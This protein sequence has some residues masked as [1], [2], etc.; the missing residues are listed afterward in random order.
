MKLTS[1]NGVI[2]PSKPTKVWSPYQQDLFDKATSDL[3][4]H[5]VVEA[6][7]GGAKTTSG[8]HIFSLLPTNISRLAVAFNKHIQAEF[9]SKLPPGSEA[10][11]YHAL[12]FAAIRSSVGNVKV[13]EWKLDNILKNRVGPSGKFMLPSIK[14]IIGI[15]KSNVV[16]DIEQVN[17]YNLCLDYGID[18]YDDNSTDVRDRIFECVIHG[19]RKSSEMVE[20]IDFDDMP[21]LPIFHDMPLRK[22]DFILSDEFQDT[23]YG[24][25]MLTVRSI[26]DGGRLYAI[27]DRNQ[28][29][30]FWRGAG[31]NAM[32]MVKDMLNADELPLSIT[33]RCPKAVIQY[34]HQQFPDIKFEGADWAKEGKVENITAEQVE[35]IAQDG[36]MILCRVNADLVPMA[37]ALIR[38]GIKASIRGRD[39]GKNLSSLIRK[40]G[41]ETIQDMLIN[42]YAYRDKEIQ[43]LYAADRASHAQFINDKVD[44]IVAI[45]ENCQTVGDILH[46]CEVLF[47]DDVAGVVLSSGHRSKGLEAERVFILR[48]DLIPHPAAKSIDEKWG[49]RCLHYVMVTRTKN[50]LYFVR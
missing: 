8:L 10:K 50:E 14:R 12:G 4:S 15:C 42:L 20:V 18:L 30:Y 11:T 28:S 23:G 9:Q 24:Q 21:F 31:R 26:S 1:E 5:V 39:I 32:S 48:P 40:V 38:K 47:S 43:K 17:L 19:Y 3:D 36:D 49:E 22:Y 2:T 7:A 41:G 13:D 27:G 37:F 46:R 6:C 44:T 29:I 33:Y 35:N 34:V 45:S 16:K 25:L